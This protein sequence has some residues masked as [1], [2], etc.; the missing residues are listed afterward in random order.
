MT[1][2]NEAA[3]QQA[4][5]QAQYTGIVEESFT[6]AGMG[7][8]VR[9]LSS[10][11]YTTVVNRCTGITN[12]IEFSTT[13]ML[14]NIAYGLVEIAGIVDFRGVDYIETQDPKTH[15]PIKLETA[16]YIRERVIAY[17]GQD[18]QKTVFRKI[19]EVAQKAEKL[20]TEGLEFLIDGESDE[21]QFRRLVLDL[22]GL[23]SK[24]PITLVESILKESGFA[25]ITSIQE[26]AEVDVVLQGLERNNVV[27]TEP[28]VQQPIEN[29]IRE[30]VHPV[31]VPIP[32]AP[33]N[34]YQQP[35]EPPADAVGIVPKK[36]EQENPIGGFEARAM[37]DL[38]PDPH[39]DRTVLEKPLEKPNVKAAVIDRPVQQGINPRFRPRRS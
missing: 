21:D 18:L 39:M 26:G 25:T 27:E 3:F 8:T 11:Q 37:G 28:M 38:P 14:W 4:L 34:P 2:L 10:D 23:E 17:W 12:N 35:V 31:E 1:T 15:Q 16:Q 9:S 32:R 29:P 13:Y 24:L 22:K 36:R 5:Q 33:S 20:A 6:A 30:P 7:F 19:A